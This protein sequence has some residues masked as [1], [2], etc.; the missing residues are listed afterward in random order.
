VDIASENPA[1]EPRVSPTRY[2][3]TGTRGVGKCR[4]PPPGWTCF[5]CYAGVISFHSLLSTY[6][7]VSTNG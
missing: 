5:A 2:P 3:D 4:F 1:E 7:I 6:L